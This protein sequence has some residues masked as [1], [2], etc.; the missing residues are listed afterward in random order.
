MTIG[1]FKAFIE[2]MGI[3]R[4]PTEEQWKRIKEKVEILE[5]LKLDYKSYSPGLDVMPCTS[6]DFATIPYPYTTC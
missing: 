6:K 1:E 5:P 4:V 3:K 2:G